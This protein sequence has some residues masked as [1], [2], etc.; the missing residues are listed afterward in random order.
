MS[1]AFLDT[2]VLVNL[3]L[4]PQHDGIDCKRALAGFPAVET[5][6]YALKEMQLGALRGFVWAHNA[7]KTEGSFTRTLGR[8]HG[9][10]R[11]LQRNLTSTSLEALREAAQQ[12]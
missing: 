2:T 6:A 4:K 8:A 7:L 12:N 10:S 9:L 3:L 5:P 11:S 1:N